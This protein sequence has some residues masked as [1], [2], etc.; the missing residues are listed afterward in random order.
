MLNV[1]D[2][3]LE[4][5]RRFLE[6]I[7]FGHLGCSRDD[8]PYVV[9]IYY[10][11]YRESIYF[12]TTEGLKTEYLAANPKICLQVEHVDDTHHWKSVIVR[13]EA[14]RLTLPET[15]EHAFSIIFKQYHTLMPPLSRTT[16]GGMERGNRIAFYRIS[17]TGITGRKTIG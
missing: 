11:Y 13:G 16:I 15:I 8:H 17:L 10:A 5:M 3:S 1:E 6:R 9:P 4:E 2:M 12:F 14:E 7:G